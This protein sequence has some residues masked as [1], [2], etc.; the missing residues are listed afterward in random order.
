MQES[1][2]KVIKKTN[3]EIRKENL[4]YEERAFVNEENNKKKR[5]KKKGIKNEVLKIT[6]KMRNNGWRFQ[7]VNYLDF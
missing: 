7:H 4:P 6:E 3:D 1:N 5:R 2:K